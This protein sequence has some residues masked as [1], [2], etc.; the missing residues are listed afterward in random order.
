MWR[1]KEPI[2]HRGDE[3][4]VAFER[5]SATA[6][7]LVGGGSDVAL[8]CGSGTLANDV[9]AATLASDRSAGTG[10][11]LV[12]GEFGAA[13]ASGRPVPLKFRVLR[14]PWGRPW[15]LAA[16]AEALANDRTIGWVWAVHLE[17]S[18]GVLNDLVGLQVLVGRTGARL[19]IDAVSSLGAVPLDLRGVHLASSTS[20]KALGA[21]AG[22]GDCLCQPG[23]QREP[24]I[25]RCPKTI[26]TCDRRWPRPVRGS[27]SPRRCWRCS[28]GHWTFTT[29]QAGLPS[30]SATMQTSAGL[31]ELV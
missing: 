19:C 12:N 28:T 16:V 7:T 23:H 14:Q 8:L 22:L 2:S 25:P 15:D 31:C 3:F 5:A 29:L 17:T 6:S 21:F 10:L 9:I 1:K 4:I 13:G 18:T 11:I 30:A 27:R 24:R 26:L 20:G